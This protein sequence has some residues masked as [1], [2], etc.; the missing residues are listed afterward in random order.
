MDPISESPRSSRENTSSQSAESPGQKILQPLRE[1]LPAAFHKL[2][3][4][5]Y[6][7]IA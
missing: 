3:V 2:R 5:S 1:G 6:F 7:P 4:Q